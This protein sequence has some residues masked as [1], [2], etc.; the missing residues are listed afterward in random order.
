MATVLSLG[1]GD[2]IM[3]EGEVSDSIYFVQSGKLNV[4][5]RKDGHPEK[6]GTVQE[7]ELV[8]EMAYIEKKPRSATVIAATSCELIKVSRDA[9]ETAMTSQPPW[10][11]A[12]I[13]GLVRRVREKNQT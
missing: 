4:F 6:V 12:F 10:L 8:G 1:P 11:Q 5:I 2:V 7:G 3:K 13:H 9:F